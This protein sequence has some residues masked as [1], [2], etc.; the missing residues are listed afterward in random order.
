M[1]SGCS[2]LQS[3]G[4][5]PE[6]DDAAASAVE[7]TYTLELSI[8]ASK[9][10][11]PDAR[12]VPSPVQVRVFLMEPS[13]DIRSIS[14]EELFDYA[15]NM[16]EPR[17]LTTLVIQPGE[18]TDI[19]LQAPTSRPTLVIAAAYRDPYQALWKAVDTVVPSATVSVS[20][21]IHA[22]GVATQQT[23]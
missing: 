11:N 2:L 5:L 21:R 10:L 9:D 19:V 17:P 8:V 23:P 22:N 3:V 20:A 15:G 4:I 13:D 12:S 14:F 18:T 16:M 6:S 7:Q 1:L